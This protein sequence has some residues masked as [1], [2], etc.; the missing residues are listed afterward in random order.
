MKRIIVCIL[1]TFLLSGC[2]SVPAFMPAESTLEPAS[3]VSPMEE[4]AVPEPVSTPSP[5]DTPIPSP[6]STPAPSPTFTTTAAATPTP[7]PVQNYRGSYFS[8]DVPGEWLKIPY[9]DGVFFYPDLSD[10]EHTFLY[11]QETDNSL[12]L[13]EVS[14]DITLMFAS[15]ESLTAMVE[16]ALAGS[17][18]TDIS[19][20]PVD[21]SKTDL[22]G[23]TCYQGRSECTSEG[24][25]YD[26]TGHIFLR[27]SKMVLLLW[28]GDEAKH[29]AGLH[30]VY[31]SIESL[32]G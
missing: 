15:P 6:S 5:T 21:I 24:E 32:R 20:S 27:G 30:T 4:T 22:N 16:G 7:V 1:C 2:V 11:Y 14:L 3:Q 12:H 23:I 10:T 31:D 18:M 26:F 19:L 25:I 13:N 28:V 9:Q 17:G 29:S 8:F